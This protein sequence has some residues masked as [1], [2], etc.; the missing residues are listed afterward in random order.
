MTSR[1]RAKSRSRLWIE[2]SL[3]A[4][5][6]IAIG[7]WVWSVAS[8]AVFQNWENWVFEREIRGESAT[9]AE[10]L[11]EKRQRITGELRVFL[12]FPSTPKVAVSHPYAGPQET[13]TPLIDGDGLVGRLV[14]PRLHLSA[15]VREGI[16][17]RTLRLALGHIPG[18]ALPGQN[19]NVG[20]AGH[21]DTLFRGLR[22][23]EKKDLIRFE[24]L[25][26][27]YVYEVEATEIVKPR[28]VSVLN[29]RE[30]P[31]LTLVTC[32]PFYCIGPAPNRFVV[33]A[34]QVSA[35]AIEQPG[36]PQ[37]TEAQGNHPTDAC[38]RS[39]AGNF[40]GGA[41]GTG[42]N[43]LARTARGLKGTGCETSVRRVTFEVSKDHSRR[44]SAG[45]SLGLTGTNVAD[46]RVNGWMWVMPDRRTIWLHNQSA[47]EPVI[48]YGYLDGKQR[49]LVITSVT[50]NSVKGYL[51]LPEDTD[52]T[53]REY[54]SG[55]R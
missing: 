12:E 5:A 39:E 40:P 25:A 43:R 17:G 29:M 31:E 46:H 44:L 34:R 22:E 26:G 37:E 30:D 33:K 11:A 35:S 16:D 2:N 27:N 6:L 36:R 21:R 14:I 23:I 10:Y 49:K 7:V 52:A 15:I 45:V 24:T 42:A 54:A 9:V 50:K 41:S 4:V 3:L 53:S 13:R 48:F 55:Q 20:I 32:Y 47:Q 51:L 19:G 28:D 8:H 38:P 1:N 18:T